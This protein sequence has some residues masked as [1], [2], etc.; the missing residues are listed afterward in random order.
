LTGAAIRSAEGTAAPRR[1]AH[2]VA[3]RQ[4]RVAGR[5]SPALLELVED[6]LDVPF[7]PVGRRRL[8]TRVRR[9]D[10]PGRGELLDRLPGSA[11]SADV[12]E[13]LAVEAGVLVQIGP[14][15]CVLWPVMIR[16]TFLMVSCAFCS[17][18]PISLLSRQG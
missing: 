16:S 15:I 6:H 3:R 7:Q 8:V 18:L 11:L 4:S 12:L 5:R 10:L 1:V 13:E 9:R 17:V 14:A 2:S